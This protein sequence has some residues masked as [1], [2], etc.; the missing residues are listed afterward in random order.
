MYPSSLNGAE[1][2]LSPQAENRPD[3]DDDPEYLTHCIHVTPEEAVI[4]YGIPAD[5]PPPPRPRFMPDFGDHRGPPIPH[6]HE[7]H[8]LRFTSLPSSNPR[9]PPEGV[10]TRETSFLV[11]SDAAGH[12]T[13][14]GVTAYRKISHPGLSV[15][16]QRLVY[17]NLYSFVCDA[18]CA[19][20]PMAT[21][22]AFRCP[23]GVVALVAEMTRTPEFVSTMIYSRE[24]R[25]ALLQ[26]A[27][28]LGAV[29]DDPRLREALHK[30]EGRIGVHLLDILD[31]RS[32]EEAARLDEHSPQYFTDLIQ[33]TI[34]RGLVITQ[35]DNSKAQ[36][37]LLKLSSVS[38]GN[39]R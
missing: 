26:T 11:T 3:P 22:L 17:Q 19:Q 15:Y 29:N 24:V 27:A 30:D 39:K 35:D 7:L 38:G 8:H 28:D 6:E 18:A 13:F 32:V 36:R 34:D 16:A 31:S 21:F 1:P 4:F 10:T 14:Q 37:I 23:A 5:L 25:D 2:D 33:N 20:S 9:V 12:R